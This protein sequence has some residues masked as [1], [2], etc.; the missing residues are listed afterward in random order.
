MNISKETLDAL[1]E[2]YSYSLY[3]DAMNIVPSDKATELYIGFE[4]G[5]SKKYDE[6]VSHIGK[7]IKA[8]KREITLD[9][10]LNKINTDKTYVAFTEYFNSLI[11]KHGLHAY[12]TTYGIGVFVLINWKGSADRAKKQVEDIL[13]ELGV[14]Y[15]TEYS[16]ARIVFRYKISKS[17]ENINRIKELVKEQPQIK[18]TKIMKRSELKSLIV[19]EIRNILKEDIGDNT[20][21]IYKLAKKMTERQVKDVVAKWVA[22]NEKEKID[23][24]NSLVRLGDSKRLACA[25]VMLKTPIDKETKEFYRM[26]YEN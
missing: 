21:E 10:I 17:A 20:Q 3:D 26:A 14:K 16:D 11:K 18:E 5:S 2:V 23:T 7:T 4:K 9:Y 6:P 24:F 1:G 8:T 19:E 13:D 12:P 22:K 15:T 25:T